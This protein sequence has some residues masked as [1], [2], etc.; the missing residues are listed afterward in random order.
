MR[1]QF[2][3][4]S[5]ISLNSATHFLQNFWISIQSSVGRFSVFG[6]LTVLVIIRRLRRFVRSELLISTGLGSGRCIE[7]VSLWCMSGFWSVLPLQENRRINRNIFDYLVLWQTRIRV[8][9]LW[10]TL[11][12]HFFLHRRCLW[13]VAFVSLAFFFLSTALF[14]YY[15]WD[16]SSSFGIFW[17]PNHFLWPFQ[18]NLRQRKRFHQWSKV[19]KRRVE[20]SRRSW[21]WHSI[22]ITCKNMPFS[23]FSRLLPGFLCLGCYHI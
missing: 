4:A 15:F 19:A 7:E 20:S 18:Q 2:F 12:C 21:E 17:S 13:K 22:T 11:V 3:T 16:P 10:P 6:F 1:L 8:S 23:K 9:D 5:A 14:F